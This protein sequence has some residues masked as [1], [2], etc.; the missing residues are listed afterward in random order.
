MTTELVGDPSTERYRA[1]FEN[2]LFAE[3]RT[4]PRNDS[5]RAAKGLDPLLIMT[6]RPLVDR[7]WRRPGGLLVGMNVF[8]DAAGEDLLRRENLDLLA[9]YVDGADAIVFA[10]DPLQV[11]SVRT[12]KA[13]RVPLP[14]QAPDQAEMV[15]RV[16]ELLR[17][18]RGQGADTRIST[19]LAVVLT[20]TDALD[21]LPP[22]SVL[23]RPGA[24]DGAYDEAE[25]LRMHDEVRALIAGWPEGEHLLGVIDGAFADC[26][27]FAVSALGTPPATPTK[28][29]GRIHPLR[30]EDPMLW[31]LARFGLVPW[32]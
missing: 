6:R 16:A 29:A 15:S 31:L 26:R 22:G 13:G 19:P 30:A 3:G 7:W 25:G 11:P 12:A 23:R 28:L 21:P 2:A 32:R 14:A 10:L 8:Y 9:K 27:F 18:Q 24:P 17:E 1:V 5:I 20:K 4:V